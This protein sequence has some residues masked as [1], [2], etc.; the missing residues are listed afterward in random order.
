MPLPVLEHLHVAIDELKIGDPLNLDEVKLCWRVNR[1]NDV[2]RR[3]ICMQPKH[4]EY[5]TRIA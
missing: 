1:V 5:E 3:L 2:K 4:F